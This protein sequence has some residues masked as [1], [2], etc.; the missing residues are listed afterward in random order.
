MNPRYWIAGI[1]REQ[2]K[3]FEG[4][5]GR[6]DFGDRVDIRI[7]LAALTD[8]GH[9]A[10][11]RQKELLGKDLQGTVEA[12]ALRLRPII[13]AAAQGFI[14]F[15][16]QLFISSFGH[17]INVFNTKVQLYTVFYGGIGL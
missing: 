11:L 2:G 3:L 15:S 10:L 6:T 16:D 7:D 12:D 9:D 14:P 17:R 1:V 13:V 5:T 8:N 4:Q